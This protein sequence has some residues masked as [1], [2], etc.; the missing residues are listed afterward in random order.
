[1]FVG[2]RPI[3]HVPT[4]AVAAT[5]APR[6]KASGSFIFVGSSRLFLPNS[7]FLLS[8][9]PTLSHTQTEPIMVNTVSVAGLNHVKAAFPLLGVGVLI[10]PATLRITFAYVHFP[11]LPQ[12]FSLLTTTKPKW[13]Q[14]WIDSWWKP[15]PVSLPEVRTGPYNLSLT[16]VPRPALEADKALRLVC[17]CVYWAHMSLY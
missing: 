3:T 4:L 7:P 1:M 17:V 9:S 12:I 11:T 2:P 5:A 15:P 6:L 8:H 14:A 16:I 10:L 13:L